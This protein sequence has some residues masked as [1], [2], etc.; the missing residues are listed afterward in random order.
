MFARDQQIISS[1]FVVDRESKNSR[2][3]YTIAHDAFT[4]QNKKQK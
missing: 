3:V 1:N 4:N 2:H